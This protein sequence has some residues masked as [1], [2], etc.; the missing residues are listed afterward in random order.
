LVAF[1]V[2]S[3]GE[4][5]CL[6][7]SLTF[8]T[9][10]YVF[11]Y[12]CWLKGSKS[13]F[14][15]SSIAPAFR[16]LAKHLGIMIGSGLRRTLGLTAR[17]LSAPQAAPAFRAPVLAQSWATG[18]PLVRPFSAL[19]KTPWQQFAARHA[20][21]PVTKC[22]APQAAPIAQPVATKAAAEAGASVDAIR[23]SGMIFEIGITFTLSHYI[24][25]F[26]SLARGLFQSFRP[27]LI[28]YVFSHI[29][30]AVFFIMGAPLWF[31]FY[32]IWMFEVGYGL[33]QCLLSLIFIGTFYGN[34][35]MP[36]VRP[37]MTAL[38]KQQKEKLARA[39]QMLM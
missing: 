1:V 17:R 9:Y 22:A 27:L 23:E 6:G 28:L 32:S 38:V 26:Q 10:A 11:A 3:L 37:T 7:A 35:L 15:S 2:R 31:S 4:L 20:V 36:R 34:L 13:G 21:A 16:D 30:K 14:L 29:L 33:F 18:R 8:V 12:P 5:C 25:I 39:A 19:I 24:H